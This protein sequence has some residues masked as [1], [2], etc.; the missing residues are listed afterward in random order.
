MV[1]ST[2]I[3][4]MELTYRACKSEDVSEIDLNLSER[5]PDFTAIAKRIPSEFKAC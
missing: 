5:D 3:M 2:R 1:K 4:V